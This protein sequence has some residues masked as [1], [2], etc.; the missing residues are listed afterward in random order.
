MNPLLNLLEHGQSYWLDNLTRPMIES[1]ELRRRVEQEGLR[2]VTSNPSTFQK[3]IAESAAYR[4]SIAQRVA[5]STADID[6]ARI[7]EALMVADIQAACEVLRPVHEQSEGWDGYVSLEV[8]PHLAYHAEASVEEARRLWHAVDRP[9]V[10][11]K[12]PGT[13]PGLA[14][15]EQLLFEG[16]NVNITLLFSVPRY[17]AV[18]EAYLRAL[19]RRA[20]EGRPLAPIASVASFFLS[21]IDVLVDE[22][23]ANRFLPGPGGDS[24]PRR[25]LGKAAIANAKLA[26]QSFKR[27]IASQRFK[28]LEA[29]GAKAQR[30]LWAS[31]G[32]KNPEYRDV[33]YVEPLI[34]PYTVNTMPEATIRAFA[35]HGT[36]EDTLEQ[37]LEEARWVMDRLAALG[38]DF[39]QVAAQLESEGVRKFIQPYDHLL[40]FLADQCRRLRQQRD[41]EPLKALSRKLRRQIIAMTTEAGSGHPT[42]SL[43]AADIV[44]A[45]LFRVMR[46]DPRD[47]KARNVDSFIL[48][49]GHA[50]PILWAALHEAGAMDEDPL[51][52]RR[53]GS[54]YEGHPTPTC[55]WIK[56]ATGSLGQGL[57]AAN[58]LA[59]ANRLDGIPAKVYCLL[60]DGECSEGAVWEAAQFAS[61]NRLSGLVAIVDVNGLEQSEPAPYRH[62]TGVL[63][64][65]FAAFGWK[66]FEVDGHDL[67][68][69]L[70]AFHQAGQDGPAAVLART[71]KGKGVSFLEG[72]PG[73]HGRALN[74]EEAERALAELGDATVRLAVPPQRVG[75]YQPQTPPPPPV[76]EADYALGAQV[77]TRQAFGKALAQLGRTMPQLVVLDGDVK[78]STYTEWFAKAFPERFFQGYIAEQNLAGVAL[79]L[80]VSGKLPVVATFAAFL[81]RAYD[82]IRMAGHSHPP[83]LVFCGSHAGVSIGEDGPSQMGLEDIALFRALLASTVLYPCDGVSA[84]R[85]TEAALTTPGIV[86]LRTTRAA[87]PVIYGPN[88][89]F[90]VGGSKLLRTSARDRFTVVAAGVTVHEALAAHQR[91]AAQGVAIRVVDAY[92]VRPLDQ[93]TLMRAARETAALVV[94]E[95]HF[96]AGG[97]G[98]AV[99]RAVSGTVP[100]HQLAVTRQPRSGTPGELLELEG[101]SRQAIER[102]IL[103]LSAEPDPG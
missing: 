26:Y 31:T 41:L 61:L 74:R 63:A 36:V 91:L 67:T 12:I 64:R 19:E 4:E 23:L 21:R 18:A 22:L 46:W 85:L 6:P 87:T 13:I 102:T 65:R 55:P 48:S 30:L 89:R 90:P 29:K 35:E 34:G 83:G 78:N 98:D 73:W 96:A 79:G 103:A 88:E 37:D 80:A 38:I 9:N 47:P 72:A 24:E 51:S 11:I 33:M 95:D 5:E 99:A 93:D 57:A 16:I 100:V 28:A 68:A 44:A 42:S 15:I 27:I 97:L 60:G 10:M 45:L 2:G 43:S 52:L 69:L 3:A 50:A 8:S 94:V 14:A 82:F 49:K 20:Q 53:L 101:I 76:L 40:E 71:V 32:T 77:A 56:V 70:E 75:P 39:D 58:G 1:G 66:T 54:P 92:S 62:D 86:Y 25:L 59:L 7:G 81:S 84:L 17:E